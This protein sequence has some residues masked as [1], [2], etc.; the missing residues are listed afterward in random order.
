[1][2]RLLTLS[3]RRPALTLAA[4]FILTVAAITGAVLTLRLDMDP[5]RMLDPD[6][7][8]LEAQRRFT[9]AFPMFERLLVAVVEAPEAGLAED[10][11][12]LLTARLSAGQGSFRSIHHAGQDPH[13]RKNG[14]LYLDEDALWDMDK[15]LAAAAPFL[16]AV[17]KDPSLR[18][19]LTML[20]TGLDN[21]LTADQ[22]AELASLYDRVRKSA[23]E[24]LAGRSPRIAWRDELFARE[25]GADGRF[26]EYVLIQPRVDFA[27]LDSAGAPLAL[28]RKAGTRIEHELPQVKVRFTG[29]VALDD[30]E[31]AAVAASAGLTTALALTLV[32]G[33]LLWGLR[34]LGLVA[35][36]LVNLL[37]GLAL[38]TAFAT[39]AVG[40]LNL[41]TVNFAVLFIGMGVDFGIQYG[42]RYRELEGL[43]RLDRLAETSR[44]LCGA[45]WLA[46]LAAALSFLAFTPTDYRGLAELGLIA[47]AGMLIAFATT[48]VLLPA[49]LRFLP[50]SRHRVARRE[51]EATARAEREARIGRKRATP[52]DVRLVRPLA[53]LAIGFVVTLAHLALLPGLTFDFNPLNLKDPA[54]PSVAAYRDL[55]ADPKATPYTAQVLVDAAA[56]GRTAERLRALPVVQK[57]VWIESYVPEAQEEKL[58]IIEGMRLALDPIFMAEAKPQPS[59][60]ENKQAL[61]RFTERLQAAHTELEHP[62]LARAARRLGVTLAKLTALISADPAR[63]KAFEAGLIDDL[64]K[65][66][67]R[68]RQLLE[69]APVSLE[70]ISPDLARR[71]VAEDGTHRIEVYPREN[72]SD[73]VALAAFVR[74]VRDLAP[75]AAGAPVGIHS[76]GEAVIGAT[77][78]ATFY[79]VVASFLL[80]LLW[81]R[82]LRDALLVLV[83]LLLALVA[84]GGSSV[85]LDLPFN[86]ANI[87]A[88]PLLIGLNNAYGTYLVLRAREAGGTRAL[89]AS[90]T[91]RA[92]LLS[93]LTT[94]GSFATL[95]VADHPG[96]ATMGIFVGLAIGWSLLFALGVLPALFAWLERLERPVAA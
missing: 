20:E 4:A 31:L 95:A 21:S 11:A 64:V 7:P 50:S 40:S 19:L 42:A 8:Y 25:A 48:L 2:S 70:G 80:F 1:M 91:P 56:A 89:L 68:L 27:R 39:L 54:S 81:L 55:L 94:A 3:A 67:A 72:L 62:T 74:A 16:G 61:L 6:L 84:M 26:R 23:E 10:A 32:L 13:F 63:L 87:I 17:A 34:S 52:P 49:L 35:A 37:V 85:A 12:T 41:I 14:L 45:L 79:A 53:I 18:G 22:A 88:L 36:V 76:G 69:A 75:D 28:A 83:P 66:L 43:R 77:L 30:E 93:G 57:V 92:V 96:M 15:R 71:Y 33:I 44:G 82:S 29:P 9:A 46:A 58:A 38:T 24:D 65:T 60:A 73:N 5:A 86:L 51:A 90:A 47:A 78:T 59:G